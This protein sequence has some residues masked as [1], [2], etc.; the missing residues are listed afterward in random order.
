MC[1]SII[2][3]AAG[4]RIRRACSSKQKNKKQKFTAVVVP[5]GRH[6]GPYTA[7]RPGRVGPHRQATEDGDERF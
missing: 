3:A 1:R 6:G 2:E 5:A 7:R 4:A